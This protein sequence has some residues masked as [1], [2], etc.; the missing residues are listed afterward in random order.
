MNTLYNQHLTSGLFTDFYELT[1]MQGYLQNDHNPQVVFDYFYRR[2]PFNSGFAIFAGLETVLQALTHLHFSEQDLDYLKSTG[3]FNNDFLQYLKNY[4]FSGTIFAVPEGS[5]V[6]PREPLLRVHAPL[7]EAQLIEGLLLNVLNFQTLVATKAARIHEA[8]HGRPIL[9][10]GLR[11][12]Q[13]PNGALMASRA[14]YIGGAQATSNTQAGRLFGIPVRGT[15]AHSW[16]MAFDDEE[17]AFRSYANLYPTSCIFLIDTYNTLGS[18]IEAAI[19]V[20][21][22]ISENGSGWGVRLDSGDLT[23]LSQEV[24]KRLDDQGFHQ[25]QIVV[26]NELDEHIIH[27]LVAD[28]APIDAWGVGT[29]MVT[30]AGDPSLTG[31]FK[32]AAKRIGNTTEYTPVIKLSNNP[33]KTT[34]PGIKQVYRY[35]DA[36][37]MLLADLIALENEKIP[38]YGTVRLFHPAL[39]YGFYDLHSYAERTPL[40]QPVM[41][42]GKICCPLPGLEDL[43]NH[44]RQELSHL[45]TTCKRLLNPH[46]YKVSFSAGLR[47]QKFNM[48]TGYNQSGINP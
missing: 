15:M 2:P 10:F 43:Q 3:R 24:R 40:L 27:Q 26:S 16:I 39:S 48:A 17:E 13:G 33:G 42:N 35:R 47:Q 20:G 7:A 36:D 8:A 29:R 21:R 37:G 25:A 28:G 5:V 31:V 6:F 32:L 18:G 19:T 12:A 45:H 4:R 9:E 34:D 22:E 30:A 41:Q 1:M 46:T 11:R 14:A 23:Y 44:V 38:A